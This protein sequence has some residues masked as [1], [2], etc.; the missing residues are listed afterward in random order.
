MGNSTSEERVG[1]GVG[2]GSLAL[3]FPCGNVGGAAPL[4]DGFSHSG[5][6]G[7]WRGAPRWRVGMGAWRQVML[8]PEGEVV[9]PSSIIAQEVA[10]LCSLEFEVG[11]SRKTRRRGVWI[12]GDEVCARS[13]YVWIG[14][15]AFIRDA[16]REG[17]HVELE[18]ATRM[19]QV[20]LLVFL[21]G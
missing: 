19:S 2:V 8:K 15:G 16:S 3:L 9:F 12:C 7:A 1:V 14:L 17:R 5:A 10:W 21:E 11:L 20:I 4:T 6:T 13:L 18:L